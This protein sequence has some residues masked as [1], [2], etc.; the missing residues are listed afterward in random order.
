MIG[1]N[2]KI[3]NYLLTSSV[4]LLGLF[5]FYRLFSL[6][7]LPEEI[8][9]RFVPDDAFYYMVLAKNFVNN[10]VWSFDTV[11]YSSG[12]HLLYGYLLVFIYM[13]FGL[14]PF[15]KLF[16]IMGIVNILMYILSFYLLS[17]LLIKRTNIYSLLGLLVVYLSPVGIQNTSFLM[18][19]M[20]P[21][22]FGSIIIFLIFTYE[23]LT[24]KSFSYIFV[25]SMLGELSRS[26]FGG[27]ILFLFLGLSLASS[28]K[29]KKISFNYPSLV[30]LFGAS[31]GLFIILSHNY[32]MFGH[33]IQSSALVK[34]YW[35]MVQGYNIQ[36]I[37]NLVVLNFNLSV[38]S[39]WILFT[40][41]ICN[42]KKL[43][44][45]NL[46]L[47]FT[48]I[49]IIVFYIILYGKNSGALQPWYISNTHIYSALILGFLFS[50]LSNKIMKFLGVIFIVFIFFT[51]FTS[52]NNQLWKHQ[53]AMLIAG[54]NLKN[55][56]K[57]KNIGTW[58]AG[59]I[60]WYSGKNIINLDGLV[61]DDIYKYIKNQN[62]L[63]FIIKSKIKYILDF[64]AMLTNSTLQLRG[65]YYCP[66]LQSNLELIKK[67]EYPEQWSNSDINLF[68]LKVPIV[69]DCY[70]DSGKTILFNSH[71]FILFDWYHPE[72][73][74]IW[75]KNGSS[76]I[77]FHVNNIN[78]FI[79]LVHFHIG[80][81]GKQE[82]KLTIN[83]QY[84]GSKTV[85]SSDTN[86][87]FKFDP[88][89]LSSDAI[90]TIKFE[91]PDAHKPNNGDQ[92]VLAM[93]LKSFSIE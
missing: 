54:K 5:L 59:I 31:F 26:D 2:K 88:K 69:E 38:I 89:L 91:F 90:N 48:S 36:P 17:K 81:L 30:A 92:R 74:I 35:S 4:F 82:I 16:I 65:G 63:S 73:T 44:S 25:F 78:T 45:N 87:T 43:F 53:S 11:H 75:S 20:F 60:S 39:F 27:S 51:S 62:L 77:K 49:S 37:L 76:K 85:D 9:I 71:N 33:F 47:L 8:L 12:F 28:F 84:I 32:Y 61:N 46:T 72:A 93:A 14:L 40:I 34:E 55:N 7:Y 10:Q 66:N 29:K 67:L 15:Q 64:K 68:K 24:K 56:I 79:G 6:A 42:Y 86:I 41:F 19:S 21:I 22:L 70:I 52:R 58:N 83:N 13:I 18:E 3:N 50:L 80:T 57:L 23:I 1:N